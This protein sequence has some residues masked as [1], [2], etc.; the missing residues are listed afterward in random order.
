MDVS[1]LEELALELKKYLP[2]HPFESLRPRIWVDK[3]GE[4]IYV[5]PVGG[6]C[7]DYVTYVKEVALFAQY[8]DLDV[9]TANFETGAGL[10][11][12]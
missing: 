5:A 10:K 4:Y 11:L 7:S 6:F 12:S 3:E 1:K 8:H 9:S 2:E